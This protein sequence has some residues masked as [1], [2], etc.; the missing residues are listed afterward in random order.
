MYGLANKRVWVAGHNGMVGA[1]VCQALAAEN[2]EILTIPRMELDLLRQSDV[3]DWCAENRPNIVIV[4]AARVGGIY[5]NDTYPADFIYQNITLETNIIHSAYITGAEKLVFLGSSCIYPKH[6]PQPLIEE[7]LL[8]GPLEPTN[9]WYA[10]AKIAGIKLCQAY[11]K[12][13]G[14]DFISTMPTNLYGPNDNY[15]DQNSHVAAALLKRIYRAKVKNE[16]SVVV[17]GTGEPLREFLFVDDCASGILFLLKH[18]SS[19]SPI[20]LGSGQ[21]I[22]IKD[23]ALMIK[24]VVGFEGDLVFDR[25]KPDGTPRKKLNCDQILSMGWAPKVQL[26]AGLKTTLEHSSFKALSFE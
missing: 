20:N 10:I 17:W 16:T 26:E 6:A 18:Y 24:K 1:A 7:S 3:E 21:E 15:H 2:C 14:C 13:Y 25:S 22:S 12:Q 5:A 9:E 23:L 19:G 11:R 4:C 8:T